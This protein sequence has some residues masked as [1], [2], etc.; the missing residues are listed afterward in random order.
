MVL[1]RTL[2]HTKAVEGD[3]ITVDMNTMHLYQAT[4]HQMGLKVNDKDFKSILISSLPITWD[5]FTALYLGSHTQNAV[6][7]SQ[8]LVT[9]I[10]DKYNQ[11]KTVPGTNEGQDKGNLSLMMMA[12]LATGLWGKKQA[13]EEKK[14][15]SGLKK[16]TCAIC[17]H[18]NHVM[19]NCFHIVLLQL[20]LVWSFAAKQIA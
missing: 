20:G 8:G 4:L 1:R 11:R 17:F 10:H 16:C 18:D 14:E 3:D 15:K 2:Y 9:I 13:R 6:M 5:A 12:Q 19:D 7:T